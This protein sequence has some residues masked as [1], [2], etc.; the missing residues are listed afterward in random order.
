M[1]VLFLFVSL[2]SPLCKKYLSIIF[3]F[4]GHLIINTIIR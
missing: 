4:F 3:E 1:I 2:Y